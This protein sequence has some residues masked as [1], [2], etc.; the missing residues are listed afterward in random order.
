MDGMGPR[1]HACSGSGVV[2][3]TG[4]NHPV[5][6]GWGHRHGAEGSGEGGR[7]PSSS[8]R[9]PRHRGCG[10]RWRELGR[11]RSRWWHAVGRRDQES[12]RRRAGGT[13]SLV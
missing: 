2:G 10:P 12:R 11:W 13:R 1:E 4:V 6:G 3:S 7:V 9:G 8:Q 5:E